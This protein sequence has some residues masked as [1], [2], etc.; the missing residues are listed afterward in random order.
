MDPWARKSTLG[1]Q[2]IR[3]EMNARE[4]GML[5]SLVESMNGMLEKRRQE[6]PEDDL[7]R[8]TGMRLAGTEPPRDAALAR[9]LPDFHRPEAEADPVEQEMQAIQS[10]GLRSL[11]ELGIIEAKQSAAALILAT[12]PAE[13]GRVSLTR[14]QAE[15]WLRGIND[16][17]LVLGSVIG[18]D[19]DTPDRLP[20][21]DPRA[22]YL[23]VYHWMTWMQDS[24]LDAV[25]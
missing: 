21:D 22:S 25:G 20:E 2:R 11:H 14:E 3:T 5:R 6:A 9:L 23:D 16:V 1:G 13:G 12:V 10:G 18:V 24:L 15:L 4:A 7:T 17:R 19:A 8:L